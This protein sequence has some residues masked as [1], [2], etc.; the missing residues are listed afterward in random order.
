MLRGTLNVVQPRGARTSA[1]FEVFCDFPTIST[2]EV[3]AY[4]Y[5]RELRHTIGANAP[6]CPV[7]ENF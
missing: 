4:S 2:V 5:R 3:F 6:P 7:V 1:V